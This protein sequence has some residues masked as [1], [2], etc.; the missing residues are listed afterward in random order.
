[1]FHIIAEFVEGFKALANS[2]IGEHLRFLK[3]HSDDE[4]Y[5]RAEQVAQLL[6]ENGFGVIT[7]GGP[8]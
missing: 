7:G 4:V 3:G 6:A 1:M 5:R 8:G 2:S